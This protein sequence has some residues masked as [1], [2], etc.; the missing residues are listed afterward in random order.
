MIT[1]HRFESQT[2]QNWKS[3]LQT[4]ACWYIVFICTTQNFFML[5][6]IFWIKKIKD[7]YF[8]CFNLTNPLTYSIPSYHT[9]LLN[10]L[11]LWLKFKIQW[12]KIKMFLCSTDKEK[13]WRMQWR[14]LGQSTQ[15]LR[16]ISWPSGILTTHRYVVQK[17]SI[18]LVKQHINHCYLFIPRYVVQKCSIYLVKQ[19]IN[20]C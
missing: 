11:P 9:R 17:S 12:L 15:M 20:H 19:H 3:C 5:F 16:W 4:V 7:S 10:V 6:S 8:Y 1:F 13:R 14:M 18:Y 2:V